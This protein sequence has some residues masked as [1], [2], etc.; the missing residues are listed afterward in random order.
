[1]VNII[2][3]KDVETFG[4][5]EDLEQLRKVSKSVNTKNDWRFKQLFLAM[6][7]EGAAD[8]VRL[9]GWVKYL[10]ENTYKANIDYLIA[11]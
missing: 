8:I 3:K 10:R 1:M 2:I 5:P 6:Y 4:L 9:S 7:Q 11:M